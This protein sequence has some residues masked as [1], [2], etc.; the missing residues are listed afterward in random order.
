[1]MSVADLLRLPLLPN[2]HLIHPFLLK[3]LNLFVTLLTLL[4]LVVL[5]NLLL[6]KNLRLMVVLL[7]EQVNLILLLLHPKV[8]CLN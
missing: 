7:R 1:M 2:D 8:L 3:S 4:G 5:Y 6:L